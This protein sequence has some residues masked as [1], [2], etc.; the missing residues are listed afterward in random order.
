MNTNYSPKSMIIFR[1]VPS[2]AIENIQLYR[3]EKT[4]TDH[5]TSK[6]D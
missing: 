2:V 1:G 6:N 5:D 4:I 3:D